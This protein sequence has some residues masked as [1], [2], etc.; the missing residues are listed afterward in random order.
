[1]KLFDHY[2]FRFYHPTPDKETNELI[3]PELDFDP[4]FESP[5]YKK[6]ATDVRIAKEDAM[7]LKGM[8]EYRFGE[9]VEEVPCVDF[10]LHSCT[11]LPTSTA[12]PFCGD[13]MNGGCGRSSYDTG[14]CDNGD[15]DNSDDE[16]NDNDNDGFGYEYLPRNEVKWQTFSGQQLCGRMI[17]HTHT[18]VM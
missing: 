2:Y 4:I 6:L 8:R 18:E 16:N 3:V 12:R 15:I 7:K 1:M 10:S 14:G 17:P 11:P 5:R 13:N 9:Y